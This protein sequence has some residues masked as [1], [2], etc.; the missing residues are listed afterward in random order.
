MAENI[1]VS[2][3]YCQQTSSN[4]LKAV[5]LIT[6]TDCESLNSNNLTKTVM[7]FVISIEAEQILTNMEPLAK[8]SD[9]VRIIDT[10]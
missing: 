10:D 3:D 4:Q 2:F 1:S 5:S 7:T 6:N 9:S 8:L